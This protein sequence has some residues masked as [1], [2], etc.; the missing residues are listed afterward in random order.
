MSSGSPKWPIGIFLAMKARRDSSVGCSFSR[1]C[2]LLMRP[3]WMV[4]TVTPS[5]ATSQARPLAHRWRAALA[6]TAALRPRG[7]MVPLMLT[8][9]P[10]RRW[11][12]PGSRAV[13]R[14]R[15]EV[16]LRANASSQKSSPASTVVGRE[17]PAQLTRMSTCA[18]GRG[19]LPGEAGK[20]I[21]RGDV[22]GY[23]RDIAVPLDPVDAPRRGGDPPA[24]L[25]QEV[26]DAGADTGAG[27]RDQA[28]PVLEFEVHWP[29]MDDRRRLA[30][31]G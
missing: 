30:N 23:G 13:V 28:G 27:A 16:K 11:R 14:R 10:Q 7:S 12:M 2:S 5:A 19:G 18:E 22:G 4:L 29:L 31:S 21:G 26:G 20:V 1:I 6:A 15:A 24:L 25:G 17:P 3:G 9:R 8:M